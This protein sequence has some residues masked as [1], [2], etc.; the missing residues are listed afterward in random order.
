MNNIVPKERRKGEWG[1]QRRGERKE[2]ERKEREDTEKR[3]E[4]FLT[5]FLG[6]LKYL[7]ATCYENTGRR[8]NDYIL[9]TDESVF[10]FRVFS[11]NKFPMVTERAQRTHSF[12]KPTIQTKSWL[13]GSLLGTGL[14]TW[15]KNQLLTIVSFQTRRQVKRSVL[16]TIAL[17]H[18]RMHGGPREPRATKLGVS[19]PGGCQSCFTQEEM[20]GSLRGGGWPQ[21]HSRGTKQNWAPEQHG[22]P[23]KSWADV[24]RWLGP[25]WWGGERQGRQISR[26]LQEA[27]RH[28]W[29]PRG[30]VELNLWALGSHQKGFQQWRKVIMVAFEKER[31]GSCHQ[32]RDSETW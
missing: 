25:A 23:G 16:R 17:A 1:K 27:C 14:E 12:N 5:D 30:S 4:L 9:S 28:T 18:T 31:C 21:T 10:N 8:Q 3:K 15:I 13:G 32:V 7:G 22:R 19:Q 26:Q 2:K 20:D 6:S 11:A 24:C 29:T